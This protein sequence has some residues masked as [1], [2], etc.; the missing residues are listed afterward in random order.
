MKRLILLALILM[1][2]AS[3]LKAEPS[4]TVNEFQAT[5]LDS[6]S[7]VSYE[8]RLQLIELAVDAHFDVDTI[9]RISLGRNWRLL[10]EPQ[11][12]Q[13]TALMKELITTT[14]AA[15]FEKSNGH[16]FSV[17]ETTPIS[18]NRSRVNSTLETRSDSARLDFQLIERDNSWLIYDIVANGVS[19]LSLKRSNYTSL[20]SKGGLDAVIA[21]IRTTIDKNRKPSD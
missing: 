2:A 12:S 9:S 8:A 19:D 3:A 13:Y 4:A 5:L 20:Y 21:D 11:Q 6:M 17:Q 16:V 10:S 7:E 14:F 1:S 15:R 18:T